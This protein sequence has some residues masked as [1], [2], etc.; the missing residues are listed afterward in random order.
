MKIK[1]S[2]LNVAQAQKLVLPAVNNAVSIIARLSK[3][4]TN[5][6]LPRIETRLKNIKDVYTQL[7]DTYIDLALKPDMLY[8][9]L[10]IAKNL[11]SKFLHESTSLKNALAIENDA[12]DTFVRVTI[13][14]AKVTSKKNSKILANNQA[15]VS[16][17]N[18][19]LM[20]RFD[21]IKAVKDEVDSKY[22]L[23][24]AA[25]STENSSD[26]QN[27]EAAAALNTIKILVE[28]FD[29]M[30]EKFINEQQSEY[31]NFLSNLHHKSF[32]D[33]GD[34]IEIPK[35]SSSRHSHT[36]KN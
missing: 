19:D 25:F 9:S 20:N 4:R 27:K 35:P 36:I 23:I 13:K 33:R 3:K 21:A 8:E 12:K 26:I 6:H 15:L 18:S 28:K 29:A 34:V 10:A 24:L 16:E 14:M 11:E 1:F 31:L 17:R 22:A 32:L 5:S 7:Y 2:F 30:A